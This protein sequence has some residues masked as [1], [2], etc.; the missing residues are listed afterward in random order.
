MRNELVYNVKLCCRSDVLLC[1]INFSFNNTF[2]KIAFRL[3]V[4]HETGIIII[5]LGS[6]W[7]QFQRTL[8]PPSSL[9]LAIE[10]EFEFLNS[11]LW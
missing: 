3:V 7:C 8:P 2:R 11:P 9:I 5:Q 6:S 1:A 10:N 4:C